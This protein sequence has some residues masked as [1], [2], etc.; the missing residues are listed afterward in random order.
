MDHANQ[1][2]VGGNRGHN[3]ADDPA[4]TEDKMKAQVE[5]NAKPLD[6]EYEWP[7]E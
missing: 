4:L 1:D 7:S 6:I 2:V 3:D 5:H